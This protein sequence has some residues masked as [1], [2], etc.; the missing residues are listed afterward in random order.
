M[1]TAKDLASLCVEAAIIMQR[2]VPIDR[3]VAL[4]RFW[5]SAV[6][7]VEA[8]LSKEQVSLLR[9]KGI[10][11]ELPDELQTGD[12]G[13]RI[14]WLMRTLAEALAEVFDETV[15]V[16]EVED[17]DKLHAFERETRPLI[18]DYNRSL[19]E[20]WEDIGRYNQPPCLAHMES[21]FGKVV[22]RYF[23]NRDFQYV[24]ASDGRMLRVELVAK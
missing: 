15:L 9:G 13:N 5:V 19:Q 16:P 22:Q 2:G 20:Y 8:R 4:G 17:E 21:S 24:I 1:K 7:Y 10:R 3:I 6:S 14:M 11:F 18:D 12:V 23:P